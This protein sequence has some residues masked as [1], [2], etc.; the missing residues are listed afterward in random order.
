MRE[1]TTLKTLKTNVAN[2]FQPLLQG[3]WLFLSRPGH[4]CLLPQLSV[5]LVTNWLLF[6][7][8]TWP[9]RHISSPVWRTLWRMP[10]TFCCPRCWDKSFDI[11]KGKCMLKGREILGNSCLFY[12]LL[13]KQ[14]HRDCIYS[15]PSLA[16][17]QQSCCSGVS[18]ELEWS[19][20]T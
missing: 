7:M 1:F 13:T 4:F 9:V 15:K 20:V 11:Q 14:N 5:L 17:E 16:L 3:K 8:T 18:G 19:M 2:N 12:F 10:L 6:Q